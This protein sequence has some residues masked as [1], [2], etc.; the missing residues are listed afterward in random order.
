MC[1]RLLKKWPHQPAISI[2]LKKLENE[3]GSPLFDRAQRY[4]HHLTPAGELLYSM[5]LGWW[6]SAT[7]P[8]R[9]SKTW[10]ICVAVR[11]VSAP[12]KKDEAFICCQS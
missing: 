9:H 2:A 8:L 4:D 12:T 11:C 1:I 6:L 10:P 3:I 5:P 7:R